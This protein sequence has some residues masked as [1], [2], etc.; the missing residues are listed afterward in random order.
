LLGWD[1]EL[2]EPLS[3]QRVR[4]LIVYA[5]TTWI[6]RFFLFLGIALLVYY[7]TFKVLGIV[8]FLIEIV[9]FILLPVYREI[10]EWMKHREHLKLNW[11]SRTTVGLLI[12]LLIWG[13]WPVS[14]TIY[15]PA[16]YK[17]QDYFTHYTPE[18][19]LLAEVAVKEGDPV[20]AGQVLLRL[21]SPQLVFEREQAAG[22]LAWIQL[23]LERMAGSSE[24]RAVYHDLWLQAQ[25]LEQQI[26][27]IDA[28]IKKLEL[29][30]ELG[31]QVVFLATLQNEQAVHPKQPL[32]SV[33]G[34]KGF[35]VVAFVSEKDIRFIPP[36]LTHA[37]FI[38]DHGLTPT[39]TLQNAV[40]DKVALAQLPYPELSS[41]QAGRVAVRVSDGEYLPEQALYPIY[42]DL[43][44]ST[45]H[46]QTEFV[47]RESG[48]VRIEGE[49]R[50]WL[51][52]QL[53]WVASVLI[54]ESG[55]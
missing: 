4:L 13:L 38:A 47:M 48:L 9:W 43:P 36:T 41:E 42:F 26:A 51:M 33:L 27:G 1:S 44:D 21:T 31:G 22:R 14:S 8:L 20:R 15:A 39:L 45:R 49:P 25:Q 30:A 52:D 24:D 32:V 16:I 2:P 6:Y 10:R 50:S 28:R 46:Q 17:A 18:E 40:V 5:W 55:F 7:L 11:R 35:Q 53:R 23:R 37:E 19:A 3:P 54:R 34:D 29:R 12:G